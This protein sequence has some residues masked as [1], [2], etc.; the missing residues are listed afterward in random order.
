MRHTRTLPTARPGGPPENQPQPHTSRMTAH[1]QRNG[2]RA[3]A[4]QV[5]LVEKGGPASDTTFQGAAQTYAKAF[6]KK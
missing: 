6:V 1:V 5:V 2:L 3:E 4:L